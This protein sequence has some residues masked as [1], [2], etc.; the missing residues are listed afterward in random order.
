MAKYTSFDPNAEIIGQ[1]MMA[2]INCLQQGN[3]VPILDKYDLTN[4]EPDKWYPLQAWLDVL[5]DIS[6][7]GSAM[8]D[9]VSIGM[10]ISES[11]VLPPE[12]DKLPFEVLI[13]GLNDTYQMQH[14]NGD[15]GFLEVEKVEDKHIKI[16]VNVP[17]PDDLEYGVAYGFA[18]RFLPEGTVYNI[19][20]DEEKTRREQGGEDDTVIHIRWK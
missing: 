9:F 12:V 3:I 18:R 11:A 6:E 14:R 2:F 4:I 16:T 1:N 5:S 13:L 8:F 10:A 20:Y 7:K 17:Y 19:K 15:A